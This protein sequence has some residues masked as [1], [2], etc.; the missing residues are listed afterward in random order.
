MLTALIR[1][2]Y[3]K[4]DKTFFEIVMSDLSY[5]G[6][7]VA[8]RTWTLKPNFQVYMDAWAES[9]APSVDEGHEYVLSMIFGRSDSNGK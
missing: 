5:L 9:I 4:R 6:N 3:S 1:E 2:G 7:T 8:Q